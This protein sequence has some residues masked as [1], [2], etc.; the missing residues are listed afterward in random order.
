MR[1][2]LLISKYVY[3]S[4]PHPPFMHTIY[5]HPL[6]LHDFPSFLSFFHFSPHVCSLPSTSTCT[7]TRMD[8]HSRRFQFVLTCPSPL[9]TVPVPLSNPS[10]LP[11]PTVPLFNPSPF[12]TVPLFNPPLSPSPEVALTSIESCQSTPSLGFF[13]FLP[14]RTQIPFNC[15]AACHMSHHFASSE[16]PRV[17]MVIAQRP[18]AILRGVSIH[19]T[20]KWWKWFLLRRLLIFVILFVRG[21]WW[22][23]T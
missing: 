3:F 15:T 2:S 12:T 5:S 7:C 9:T 16:L 21:G 4:C 13:P 10:P 22:I 23:G 19:W 8:P 14:A 1:Q 6:Y 17:E 18:S 11:L 20:L